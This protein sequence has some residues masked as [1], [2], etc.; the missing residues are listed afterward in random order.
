[1]TLNIDY[2][3]RLDEQ[4]EQR[5]RDMESARL[6]GAILPY[7]SQELADIHAT[8]QR[9]RERAGDL[10]GRL[11]AGRAATNTKGAERDS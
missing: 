7:S 6:S 1:M 11:L 9:I 2:T 4:M 5:T 10:A 3:Y 8:E